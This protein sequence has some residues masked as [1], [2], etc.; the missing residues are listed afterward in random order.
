MNYFKLRIARILTDTKYHNVSLR[1]Y[2]I[3]R[4]PS[5]FR[6]ELQHSWNC[7]IKK[8]AQDHTSRKQESWD[9]NPI[10]CE[11]KP[12]FW[13]MT[14]SG[15]QKGRLNGARVTGSPQPVMWGNTSGILAFPII[16]NTKLCLLNPSSYSNLYELWSLWES[17]QKNKAPTLQEF[18]VSSWEKNMYIP[19]L[20]ESELS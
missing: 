18:I 10:P 3:L 2:N 20:T 9:L 7:R 4:Y 6:V 16:N 11:P 1:K 13:A 12:G 17:I 14:I 19:S 5:E 15:V 8:S